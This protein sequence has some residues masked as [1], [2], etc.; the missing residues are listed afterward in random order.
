VVPTVPSNYWIYL[1]A[2]ILGPLQGFLNA[3]V[4]FSRDRESIQRRV[5]QSTRKLL[6]RFGAIF[7]STESSE[8]VGAELAGGEEAKQL[9]EYSVESEDEASQLK[10]DASQLG[11][12]EVEKKTPDGALNGQGNVSDEALG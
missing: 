7:T 1:L 10:I 9:V 3:L 12:L 6:S 8:A 5:S 11:R 2:A 4:V